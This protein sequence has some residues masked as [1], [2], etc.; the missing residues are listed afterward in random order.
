MNKHVYFTAM[1]RNQQFYIG[2]SVLVVLAGAIIRFVWALDGFWFD[3]IFSWQLAQNAQSI[4]DVL[5]E[6]RYDN[7]HL[8][9]TLWMH[10]LREHASSLAYRLPFL[11][12][13]I[14]TVVLAGVISRKFNAAAPLTAMLLFSTSLLLTQYST[15]ARGYAPVVFFGLL[16]YFIIDKYYDTPS[17]NMRIVF[18][19]C[20]VLGFASHMTFLL[21][22]GALAASC[23]LPLTA[24]NC[25]N[26]VSWFGLPALAIATVYISSYKD[27]IYWTRNDT[28]NPVVALHEIVNGIFSVGPTAYGIAVSLI[29]IA[30]VCVDS[31]RSWWKLSRRDCVFFGMMLL[32]FGAVV[33]AS[34]MNGV[35][36]IRFA[37]LPIAFFYL[38]ANGY[39]W[40]WSGESSYRKGFVLML[41]LCIAT[42]G[43]I[44]VYKS[45]QF[46]RGKLR[47]VLLYIAERSE[48]N[49][50]Q[51][52]SNS[53]SIPLMMK[54]YETRINTPKELHYSYHGIPKQE[55]QD[56]FIYEILD[57][58]ILERT[59][60]DPI[61]M[62][63]IENQAWDETEAPGTLQRNG[64]QYSLQEAFYHHGF[65]GWNMF[66]YKQS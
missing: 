21:P 47:D 1:T 27:M 11:L 24:K 63:F 65:S 25:R 18:L 2:A 34:L 14:A 20:S 23:A 13:G 55:V 30:W 16:A 31:L 54:F 37:I 48:T 19:L 15:E 64:L 38:Q 39:L 51:I 28:I 10:L 7:N 60:T 22:L 12:C 58:K 33:V 57:R 59:E 36:A 35:L 46:E 49:Q 29:L 45:M 8:L 41:C 26:L 44:D 66:V 53:A 6:T 3:E 5:F 52:G 56:A 62:W 42:I 17:K 4:P 32:G 61:P 9:I 43:S 50:V 40:Q